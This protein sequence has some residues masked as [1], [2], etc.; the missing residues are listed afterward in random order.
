MNNNIL[1]NRPTVRKYFMGQGALT[2]ALIIIGI[3]LFLLSLANDGG[4]RVILFILG[5]A[6]I[7][8][9]IY[10]RIKQ[11]FEGEKA[12][13]K[14]MKEEI[15]RLTQ[16]G[17]QKLKDTYA[18]IDIIDPVVIHGPGISPDSTMGVTTSEA[19]ERRSFIRSFLNRYNPFSAIFSLFKKKEPMLDPVEKWKIGSDDALRFMLLQVTIYVFN[20]KQVMAYSSNVDISTGMIYNESVMEIFYSDISCITSDQSMFKL[21]NAKK[22]KFIYKMRENIIIYFNG[23]HHIA[24]VNTD[25]DASIVERQFAGM[26]NLI[27]ERK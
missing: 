17:I 24:S 21:F 11:G 14:A 13:D 8:I 4:T 5:I 3:V 26:K 6:L 23:H 18:G 25:F 10:L 7:G 12:V 22:K 20:E 27:R 2:I 9:A 16:R 19:M 1:T 15:A